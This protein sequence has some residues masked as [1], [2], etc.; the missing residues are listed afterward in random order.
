M[1]LHLLE[2]ELPVSTPPTPQSPSGASLTS[3][4]ING[5]YDRREVTMRELANLR[6]G[7]PRQ[8]LDVSRQ[9][10]LGWQARTEV[11]ATSI[12]YTQGREMGGGVWLMRD[13]RE[14]RLR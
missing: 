7:R 8:L 5:H 6:R 12:C 14:L 2:P 9:T 13:H 10:A 1:S 4:L 11:R 3:A